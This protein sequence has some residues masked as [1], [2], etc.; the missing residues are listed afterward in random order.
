LRPAEY[1]AEQHI[2]LVLNS[3]VLAIDTEKKQV[4]TENGKTYDFGTLLIATG[5]EP[6]KLNIPGASDSRVH[7]LRT[8]A[9]SKAIIAKAGS[10]KQAVV[11]GGSFIGSEVAA[12][13]RERGVAVHI[14]APD[15]IPLERVVG[16]EIGTFIKN[17]HESHGVVFHLGQTVSRIDG[18]QITLS[19]GGTLETDL[20]VVG[21]G[22]RPSLALAEQAGLKI[23]QGVL[24][25]EYLETSVPGIFAAGDIARYP[26]P[27]S[28]ALT[29]IEHWV[30]A[31]LQGQVAAK[32]M[33]GQREKYSAVPFFWTA[34]YGVSLRYSGH[35]EKWD[36]TEID[37]RIADKNFAITYKK[38]GK[39]LALATAERD[40]QN[41][42]FA[43]NLEGQND[44]SAPKRAKA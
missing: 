2:D 35:A 1:Y 32:N 26:D 27:H 29:R 31:E 8:F 24:V 25:N 34:L 7:Y 9:D 37:G 42:K 19:G 40:L 23:D 11:I 14:I 18:S 38:A 17:L 4:R 13:L 5:A 36:A 22:V 20:I 33:L 6:V 39:A 15:K 30:V 21:A 3:R 28:G 44:S 16:A 41:L 10:A 43:A 12:S